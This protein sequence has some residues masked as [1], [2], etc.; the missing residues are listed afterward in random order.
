[1]AEDESA[2]FAEAA[3]I[4]AHIA[5]VVAQTGIMMLQSMMSGLVQRGIF[6]EADIV[7]MIRSLRADIAANP[8]IPETYR[9]QMTGLVGQVEAIMLEHAA[10][11]T[12][13]AGKG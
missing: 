5:T 6:G 13:A 7:V 8:E 3:A 2:K 9:D 11:F 10:R 12:E 4:N 1:M